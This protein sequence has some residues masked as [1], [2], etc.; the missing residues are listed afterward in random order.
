MTKRSASDNGASTRANN[1][2]GTNSEEGNEVDYSR[3]S[4]EALF[5]PVLQRLKAQAKPGAPQ[6]TIQ[7]TGRY[8]TPANTRYQPH[9][10]F[11]MRST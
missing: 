4:R 2:S 3:F 1:L 6:Q 5:A 10:R 7:V 8:A 9:G 11:Q